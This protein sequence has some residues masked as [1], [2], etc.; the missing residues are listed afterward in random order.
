ME[1]PAPAVVVNSGTWRCLNCRYVHLG[2][3]PLEICPICGA[4]QDRFESVIE[5]ARVSQPGNGSV[6]VI[7]VGGGIAG[8]SAAAAARQASADAEIVLLSREPR[9][10]YYRLNLTRYLAG[11]IHERDLPIHSQQWYDDNRI[12]VLLGMEAAQLQLDRHLIELR[13]G[14]F[15]PFGKLLVTAGAHP[16]IPPIVGA[17]REGVVSLRTLD[18]AKRILADL[19][20]GARCVCIGG[21]LLGLETAGALARRGARVTLIEGHGWLMPRQL[22]ER[23]SQRLQEHVQALG[24]ALCMNGRTKE[25]LGDEKAAGV[26][27]EDGRMVGADM[28]VIAAGVRPNSY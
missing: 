20:E 27:L 19:R 14:G 6:R 3:S 24:I 10:P 21:G 8:I 11:E 16:F 28:V 1:E 25:I 15:E 26:L 12:Q 4:P 23:A 7:I 5:Q 17:Q 9:L 2:Q 22:T 13:D 18:D